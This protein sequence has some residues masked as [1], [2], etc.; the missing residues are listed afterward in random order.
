[1]TIAMS[2]TLLDYLDGTVDGDIVLDDVLFA[3]PGIKMFGYIDMGLTCVV[4]DDPPGGGTFA[5][6]TLGQAATF[7]AVI[8]TKAV[9]TN[10]QFANIIVGGALPFPFAMQSTFPLPLVDG[11]GLFTGVSQ[12][13]VT[14]PVDSY[15]TIT[16][17]TGGFFYVHATGSVTLTTT[18]TFPVTPSVTQCLDFLSSQGA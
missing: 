3:V 1:M 12:V 14:Q 10:Q 2:T 11:L 5:Y 13:E 18:D 7:D 9:L 15:M 6:D 4:L 16:W 17:V 8:N